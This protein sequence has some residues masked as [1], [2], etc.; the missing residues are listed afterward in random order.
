MPRRY[1]KNL[2]EAALIEPLVAAAHERSVRMV[3]QGVA[4]LSTVGR[5]R[6]LRCASI[7]GLR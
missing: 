1:W 2:P 6:R 7:G 3:E 5:R 4:S